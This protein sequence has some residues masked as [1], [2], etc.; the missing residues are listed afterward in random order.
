MTAGPLPDKW[1]SRDFP[2]LIEVT[3]RIDETGDPVSMDDVNEA[4]GMTIEEAWSAIGALHRAG[5]L[6]GVQ[7]GNEW[8]A[9][10]DV[11]GKAYQATGLHPGDDDIAALVAMFTAAAEETSDPAEKTRLRALAIG[12]RD[13]SSDVLKRVAAAYIAS[14]IPS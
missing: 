2:M 3:R 13:V 11:T 4:L 8:V 7:A 10:V 6:V 14:R 12:I 5:F 9:V 1:Y